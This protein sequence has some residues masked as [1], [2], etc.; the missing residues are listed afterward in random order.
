VVR[1]V[2]DVELACNHSQREESEMEKK[3]EEEFNKLAENLH[4]LVSTT[5]IPGVYK[6]VPY[7]NTVCGENS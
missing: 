3:K 4:H 6:P 5:R 7:C 1:L 2:S